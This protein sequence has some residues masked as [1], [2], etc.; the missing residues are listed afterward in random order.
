MLS[1]ICQMTPQDVRDRD[2]YNPNFS[3]VRTR[4]VLW[5]LLVF[6]M[7]STDPGA[8]EV[9]ERYAIFANLHTILVMAV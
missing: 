1:H 9:N 7:S 6:G 3:A 5:V 8:Q 4:V 2:M